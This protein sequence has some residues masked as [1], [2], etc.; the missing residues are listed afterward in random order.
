[1]GL[2]NFIGKRAFA[3]FK[4]T[5]DEMQ[6][7]LA[8]LE[9]KDFEKELNSLRESVNSELEKFTKKFKKLGK[10]YV[11]EIPYDRD[12]QTL[13]FMIDKNVITVS[14]ETIEETENG[15]F[16]SKNVTTTT[17]PENVCVDKF[18]QK[19]LKEEKKMLFIF[20][21][22]SS[23]KEETVNDEFEP[24]ADDEPFKN[25]K[26]ELVKKMVYMHHNGCS[27]RKIAQECGVSDKTAKRWI[28]EA[29]KE[30]DSCSE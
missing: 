26:E 19:Y 4:S 30:Q 5:I 11:V 10:K 3:S 24:I 29:L 21:D 9:T 12:T 20:K 14:V 1:M 27:Y 7:A 15:S 13:S 16:K 23:E 25:P 28:E 2:I 17:I 6:N 8:E 18:T 22:I